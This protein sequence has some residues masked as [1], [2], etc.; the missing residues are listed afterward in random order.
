[1]L[2]NVVR[3]YRICRNDTKCFDDCLFNK[4]MKNVY[5]GNS[6]VNFVTV[7]VVITRILSREFN[8]FIRCLMIVR[9]YDKV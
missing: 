2:R 5:M 3:N 4:L 7:V 1:M 6:T 9:K 8:N